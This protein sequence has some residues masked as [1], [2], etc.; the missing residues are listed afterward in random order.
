MERNETKDKIM[1]FRRAYRKGWITKQQFNT[2]KGQVLS[3]DM[4]AAHKGY[5]NIIKRNAKK[6]KAQRQ[7]WRQTS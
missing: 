2:L 1:Y 4:E 5:G 7:K 6:K 3:G